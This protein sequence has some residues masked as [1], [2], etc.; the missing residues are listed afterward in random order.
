MSDEGWRADLHRDLAARR[1]KREV[2][3]YDT[4][5]WKTRRAELKDDA[6]CCL[7]IRFGVYER[8]TVADHIQPARDS[9]N[10]SGELQALCFSCHA[11]KRRI[12]NAWRKGKLHIGEL[13]LSR[14]KEALRQRACVF[15][16]GTDGRDLV[17]VDDDAK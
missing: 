12:E 1:S 13:N 4:R 8:A 16:V 5:E 7:C 9:G 15:G 6:V 11:I 10:F 2:N 3:P 14:G 17:R